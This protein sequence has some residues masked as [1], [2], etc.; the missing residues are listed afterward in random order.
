M[1]SDM[2][3]PRCS[4]ETAMR[5]AGWTVGTYLSQAVQEIDE[6]FGK[7][8]AVKH[9]ELLAACVQAQTL[10][11]NNTCQMRALWEIAERVSD[12]RQSVAAAIPE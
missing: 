5:Q 12:A 3:K 10:D 9:P 2:H 1:G 8:F 6:R 7:G 4:Y 11:F